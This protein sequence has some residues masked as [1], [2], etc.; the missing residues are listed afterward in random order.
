MHSVRRSASFAFAITLLMLGGCK[1]GEDVGPDT[2]EAADSGA[3]DG[4]TRE[5]IREQAQPMTPERAEA[6]GIIDT[7][8]HIE[9]PTIDLD[10]IIP[11]QVPPRDTLDRG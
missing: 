9:D 7:T 8:I 3:L 2:V 11:V 1:A 6:L 5:Q 10:T 4:L